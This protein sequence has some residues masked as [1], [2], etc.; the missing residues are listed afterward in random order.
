MTAQLPLVDH[1]PAIAALPRARIG[2][3]P[4]RVER[5]DG[6]GPEL[7]IKRD[8]QTATALGGNK[9]RALEF[10]LGP[11]QPGAQV[12]T[13]GSVASTHAFATAVHAR[14]LGGRPVLGLWTQVMNP[15]AE[16]IARRIAGLGTRRRVFSLPPMAVVW[17][18][19]QR[20]NGAVWIPPGGTSPLGMLGH[21]NGALELATQISNGALPEPAR[22]VVPLGTGGTAAGLA[23]GCRIAGLRSTVVAVRVA[24]RIVARHGRVVRLANATGR[25]LRQF[26]DRPIPLVSAN[27]VRVIQ[28]FYGGAYGRE[29]EAGRV[30]DRRFAEGAGFVL[31]A[32]YSAKACA[33]VL[34]NREPG[35]TLLW[36]TFDGRMLGSG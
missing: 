34:A 21:V 35:V 3:Y 27:D 36:L 15:T 9:V 29:I 1:F 6:I 28:E 30:A 10:L 14:E 18:A 11:M 19:I 13:V 32:T 7:W 31:D 12:V 33:A 23:L 5:A 2:S 22:I 4:T 20:W 16:I 26:S 17:A 8:D 24:P 25:L